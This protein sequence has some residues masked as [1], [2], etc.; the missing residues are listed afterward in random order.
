MRRTNVQNGGFS[1]IEVL[2][3][4]AIMG[5]MAGMIVIDYQRDTSRDNLLKAAGQVTTILRGAAA[6]GMGVGKNVVVKLDKPGTPDI[7]IWLDDDYDRAYDVGEEELASWN[8]PYSNVEIEFISGTSSVGTLEF[9]H[10]GD[11]RLNSDGFG[12]G[13][14]VYSAMSK[15]FLRLRVVGAAQTDDKKWYSY[16]IHARTSFVEV[17]S[18]YVS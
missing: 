16:Y 6:A 3:V 1:L 10:R 5:I 15:T 8:N 17:F 18:K 12:V 14:P 2:I 4:V 13:A 7:R 9:L 11:S